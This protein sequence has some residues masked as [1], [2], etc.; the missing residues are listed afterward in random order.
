MFGRSII[1]GRFDSEIAAAN[2]FN[3]YSLRYDRGELI[4]LINDVPYMTPEEVKSHMTKEK[5]LIELV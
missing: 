3:S 4:K 2:A 5:N 1:I